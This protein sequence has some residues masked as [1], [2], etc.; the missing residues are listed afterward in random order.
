MQRIEIGYHARDHFIPFHRRT[1]RWAC[2]VAHRRCG[3][4]YAAIHDVVDHAL[5]TPKTDARYALGAP[6]Y[7]QVK[8]VMWQYLKRAT[9]MLPD[10]EVN[11]SELW[12]QLKNGSRIRLYALDTSYER[13]RGIYLD[14]IVMDE[15]ADINPKAWD[16]VIRPALSDRQGW[17][18]WIGTSK[19]RDAFYDVWSEATTHPDD[20]FV[21]KLK[22][23]ETGILKPEEMKD[24]ERTM[25][26]STYAREIECSF[27][28]PNINQLISGNE[29]KDAQS[30][31]SEKLGPKVIGVDVARFGDDRTVI[32]TRN[33]DVIDEVFAYRG[34]DTMQTVG[35]VITA[36]EAYNP[37]A[38]FIDVVGIGAGVVDR[39]N[40]LRYRVIDVKSGNKAMNDAKF[41]NVR[42]EMWWKMR[43]WIRDRGQIPVNSQLERDLTSVTYF[44]DHRNRVQLESKEDMKKR[45]APSPDMG[46][47][48]AMTFAQPVAPKEIRDVLHS[49]PNAGDYDPF[50]VAPRSYARQDT[51]G[52]NEYQPFS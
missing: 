2:V 20:W 31:K 29:I 28:E 33:G 21:V 45:K 44:F 42:A 19:G 5:R 7:S 8:D 12:V 52:V 36:I 1:Q 39:L 24:M 38:V 40:Q 13:M 25:G 11:E 4:T 30:R 15:Y 34:I 18:V 27:D 41:A 50:N 16:E 26:L 47:A 23:S 51:S 3:K 14:G 9:A 32:V 37:D 10:V 49:Q 6:T 35:Q 43:D 46:D 48:L 17:A 22:G